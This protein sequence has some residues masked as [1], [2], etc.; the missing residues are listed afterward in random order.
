MH[1]RNKIKT[2]ESDMLNLK[3]ERNILADCLRKSHF[4]L[5][6]DP[7]SVF[8]SLTSRFFLSKWKFLVCVPLAFKNSSFLWTRALWACPPPSP[9]GLLDFLA[10]KLAHYFSRAS[11]V[12]RDH[13]VVDRTCFGSCPLFFR[14]ASETP[15]GASIFFCQVSINIRFMQVYYS[16]SWVL[17]TGLE[18]R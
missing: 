1:R 15:W 4:Y 2:V 7:L 8:Q 3:R 14:M 18:M 16:I 11:F 17:E 13:C 9:P 6:F 5:D 12:I 10:A